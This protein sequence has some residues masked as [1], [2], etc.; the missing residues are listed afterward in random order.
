MEGS[1]GKTLSAALRYAELGYPV[2]PC[3]PG[4]KVPLT[5]HGF[6]DATTDPGADRGVVDEAPDA[7]IGLATAGSWSSTSTARTTLAGG[8][9]AGPRISPAV[10][11]PSRRGGAGTTSSASR[12][13]RPGG[14]RRGGSRP[15]STPGPNGGYIV[16]PPSVVD[17]QAV[18]VGRDAWSWTPGR[19]G[20]PRAARLAGGAPGPALRRDPAERGRP[21]ARPRRRDPGRRSRPGRQPDPGRPTERHPGAPGRA[22]CAGS[23]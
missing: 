4:G 11:C 12:T 14:T 5:P 7:N 21:R 2:F 13:G 20:L 17:G 18:P 8:P 23:G 6:Q 19:D 1:H 9:G 10:R 22:P 15:R 3:V 16:V